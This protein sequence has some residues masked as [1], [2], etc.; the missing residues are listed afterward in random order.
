MELSDREKE[1]GKLYTMFLACVLRTLCI[2]KPESW[3]VLKSILGIKKKFTQVEYTINLQ[4]KEVELMFKS[5]NM[6]ILLL[7]VF[8][9][10]L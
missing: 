10:G 8:G 1:Q 2:M 4:T 3:P 6:L 7:F 5:V 9:F